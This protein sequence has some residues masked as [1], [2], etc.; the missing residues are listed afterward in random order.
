MES[1]WIGGQHSGENHV[2]EDHQCNPRDGGSDSSPPC[3]REAILTPATRGVSM[4]D[5]RRDSRSKRSGDDPL[6]WRAKDHRRNEYEPC[7]RIGDCE[8]DGE[9]VP[10]SQ[11]VR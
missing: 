11:C 8:E 1:S 10:S 9:C 7:P 4:R 5:E 2:R 3:G 6:R